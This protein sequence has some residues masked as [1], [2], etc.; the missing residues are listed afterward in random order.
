MVASYAL[1]V[2]HNSSQ[3]TS[4]NP[5]RSKV[6]DS[7]SWTSKGIN[8]TSNDMLHGRRFSMPARLSSMNGGNN[9][10]TNEPE[11]NISISLT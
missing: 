1:I 10:V 2:D 3:S 4:E 8:L 11:V 7:A 5:S 9:L 6:G